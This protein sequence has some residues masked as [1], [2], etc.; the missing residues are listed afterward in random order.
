MTLRL[1][2]VSTYLFILAEAVAWFA[3]LRAVG[4]AVVR[5]AFDRLADQVQPSALFPGDG[6]LDGV[7]PGGAD[8]SDWLLN[9]PTNLVLDPDGSLLVAVETAIGELE[10][11]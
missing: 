8:G 10:V 9:H 4:T 5:G 2:D 6:P 11:L 1:R 3:V 7:P